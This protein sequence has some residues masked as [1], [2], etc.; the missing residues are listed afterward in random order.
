MNPSAA[1]PGFRINGWHVLAALVLFFAADIA[2]NTLFIVRAYKT[3][4]GEVSVTPYEDGLL[5]D[6]ALK[7]K[8]AQDALGWRLTAGALDGE[9]ITV[10]AADA[11]G[12]AIGG[13]T[14]SGLLQ[15]PATETGKRTVAF[16]EVSPGTYEARAGDLGGAWDLNLTATDAK[17]HKFL[18]ERRLVQP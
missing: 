7:Q 18:A 3:F 6:A 2:I 13:L 9:R 14:V 8:T 15:R 12:A 1:R 16:R 17:G 5:Y 10:T 4:P 11:K